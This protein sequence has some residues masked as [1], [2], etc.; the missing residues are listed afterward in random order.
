VHKYLAILVLRLAHI[1]IS[2]FW[3]F[4]RYGLTA[5]ILSLWLAWKSSLPQFIRP[6]PH[7]IVQ[8]IEHIRPSTQQQSRIRTHS[9]QHNWKA[10]LQ[11]SSY[12]LDA[13]ALKHSPLQWSECSCRSVWQLWN[14]WQLHFT[15]RIHTHALN[16]CTLANGV[17]VKMACLVVK[18]VSEN[19]ALILQASL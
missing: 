6:S 17:I 11:L 2:Y 7:Q 3:T 19:G 15:M 12:L 1:A 13:K 18:S 9:D 8:S 16:V 14:I 4:I 5:L 10:L